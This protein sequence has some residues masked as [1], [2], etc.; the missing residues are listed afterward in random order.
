MP[1]PQLVLTL[2]LLL[3]AIGAFAGLVAGLLGVGGGIILVPALLYGFRGLGYDGPDLMRICLATSL[4]TIVVTSTRSV[5]SH[6]RRGAVD[7]AVLR[8][9]APGIVLG[10]VLG[11]LVAAGLETSALQGVFGGLGLIIALYLAFGRSQWR[12]GAAMPTGAVRA[13]LSGG[14][15]LLSVLMG[16]GG[17]SFAVPMMTLFGRAVHQAVATAA[18]FGVLLA[19][20][21]TLAFLLTP[22]PEAARPP[23]TIGSVNAAA[24][25]IIVAMTLLTAPVGARLAHALPAAPL[26]RIFALFLGAV[27]GNMLIGA[28]L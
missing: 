6:N 23:F 18:G 22:V 28:A 12:L 19:L 24:F 16:I 11:V 13:A 8:G 5:L 2:A 3:A 9:W 25:A 17:G 1:D 7:W 21:S 4:A 15:G 26:R 27:A 20:P 10:A 14:V